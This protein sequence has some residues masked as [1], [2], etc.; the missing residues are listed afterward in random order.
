MNSIYRKRSQSS[1]ARKKSSP[2]KASLD[3]HSQHSQFLEIIQLY[4]VLL[5]SKKKKISFLLFLQIKS[6]WEFCKQTQQS[7]GAHKKQKCS[8]RYKKY[9]KPAKNDRVLP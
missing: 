1:L 4:T 3:S 5:Q 2:K 7:V 9:K 8:I 6:C